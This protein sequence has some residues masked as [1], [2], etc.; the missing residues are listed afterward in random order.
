MSKFFR[1][2]F[3]ITEKT[4]PK[5]TNIEAAP[6]ATSTK[7]D[8]DPLNKAV[9]NFINSPE[10]NPISQTEMR[11]SMRDSKGK[12][13][14]DNHKESLD[15]LLKFYQASLTNKVAKQALI[16]LLTVNSQDHSAILDFLE[17]A[18]VDEA[19]KAALKN[20]IVGIY[21]EDLEEEEGLIQE[22]SENEER[23]PESSSSAPT[24]SFLPTTEER[25]EAIP[26]GLYAT[27]DRNTKT[28]YT[29]SN[30]FRAIQAELAGHNDQEMIG[31][32]LSQAVKKFAQSIAL[33]SKENCENYSGIINTMA[34]EY[35]EESLSYEGT[36]GDLR[37]A[38]TLLR[39]NVD[40]KSIKDEDIKNIFDGV[41]QTLVGKYK[42]SP[43][44]EVKPTEAVKL[45]PVTEIAVGG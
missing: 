44:S 39:E 6:S 33:K 12:P 18:K 25:A 15:K 30:D 19:L 22:M 11:E 37:H 43:R 26:E 1:R 4:T 36:K 14:D 29:L 45:G 16:N 32:L 28:T 10:T 2:I 3:G 24:I 5:P 23:K 38:L 27:V 31:D 8:F 9:D 21:S 17:N 42:L 41:T 34:Q 7:E 13:F 40:R 20:E 35:N